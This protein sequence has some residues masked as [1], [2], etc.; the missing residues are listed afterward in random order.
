M[1]PK[2]VVFR[3][4]CYVDGVYSMSNELIPRVNVLQNK[5]VKETKFE[6]DFYFNSE[7]MKVISQSKLKVINFTDE[8]TERVR[9]RVWRDIEFLMEQDAIM[10]NL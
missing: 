1:N 8:D 10:Y 2:N 4:Q 6:R 7:D 3:F 5:S 9:N